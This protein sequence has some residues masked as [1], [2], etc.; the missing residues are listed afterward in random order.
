[1][2]MRDPWRE[3]SRMEREMRRWFDELWGIKER[4]EGRLPSPE[5]AG[6]P[7]GRRELVGTPPV[8]LIDRGDSLIL[9]SEVP[10][11]KK[12]NLKVSVTE[13]EVSISGKVER[14]REAEKE[15]Y[16]Y[17]ERSY[18]A[19]QRRIPLPVKVDSGKAKAKYEDGVLE[20]IL[21]KVEGT[22]RRKELEIE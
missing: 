10:G 21:P 16:Y 11:V 9:R 5:K 7:V 22:E 19:W 14:K 4:A 2:A 3:F 8:D 20:I 1:M 17:A 12:E 6:L 15:N 13:N 18:S